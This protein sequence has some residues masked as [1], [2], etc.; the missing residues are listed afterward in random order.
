MAIFLRELRRNFRPWLIWSVSLGAFV[1]MMMAIYP[2]IASQSANLREMMKMYPPAMLKAFN[3]DRLDMADVLG[4]YATEGFI[5]AA[6]ISAIYSVQL[7]SGLLAKEES[8][9]TIEF[10]LAKPVTRT[11]IVTGKA[12]VAAL[13]IIGLN[14]LQT[15]AALAS[16]EAVKTGPYSVK[17]F[18]A[19]A[20]GGLLI[21]LTFAAL[22]LAVAVFVTKA[23]A[24]YPLGIGLVL[25][26]YILSVMA[27]LSSKLS[28]L[29]WLS[30]FS[31]ADTGDILEKGAIGGAY[32]TL[33]VVLIVALTAVAYTV[34][35]RKD[36]AV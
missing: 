24:L 27:K 35:N 14:G 36:I 26:T 8:D 33:F 21:D 16:F 6:L 7:A 10:L 2:T 32:L 31:Y 11:T 5:L 13:Y 25:G 4:Y 30:P 23:K 19:L 29:R 9:K 22:G 18:L 15:L 1:A 20:A 3:L 12:V 28:A 17:A 34:Y